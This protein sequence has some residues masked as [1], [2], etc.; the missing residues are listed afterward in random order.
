M[1]MNQNLHLRRYMYMYY[2]RTQL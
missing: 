1:Q 2:R